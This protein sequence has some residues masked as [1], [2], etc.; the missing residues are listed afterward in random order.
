MQYATVSYL[1]IL[2]DAYFDNLARRYRDR[3]ALMVA[4]LQ[5]LGFGIAVPQGAYYLFAEYRSV[6]ALAHYQ[7]AMAAAMFL[8]T[9]VGVAC[10]P[11]D[12]F[13]GQSTTRKRDG[14][15]YLRFAAC[16]SVTDLMEA[17]RRLARLK[18]MPTVTAV[19]GRLK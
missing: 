3:V 13:Y 17:S 8:L 7:S 6:P 11:G 9:E 16:R 15:R 12:N 4:V 18:T 5:D 1:T 14:E 2:P 10:V 19:P